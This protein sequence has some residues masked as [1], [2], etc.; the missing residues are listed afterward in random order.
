[1]LQTSLRGRNQ[2][3]LAERA[4]LTRQI[5]LEADRCR[6][7][8]VELN[9]LV[10]PVQPNFQLNRDWRYRSAESEFPVGLSAA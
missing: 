1:M 7:L 2:S 4:R 9:Q 10:L 3:V 6:A 8:R 5:C